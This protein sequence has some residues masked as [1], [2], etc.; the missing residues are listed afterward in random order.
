MPTNNDNISSN[1]YVQITSG[2][3]GAG[4]I[5]G[6]SLS[7]RVISTNELIP[8]GSIIEFSD[9]P[10]VAEYFGAQAAESARASYY[11]GY[12]SK[13]ISKPKKITFARW[14]ST[15]TSAQVFGSKSGTLADL[16]A[17]TTDNIKIT[18]DGIEGVITPDLSTI[19]SY[20]DAATIL[21][22]DIQALA[23]TFATATVA[24]DATKTSFNL[25]T[26]GVADGDI[27]ISASNQALLDALGWSNAINSAGVSAQSITEQLQAM[28]NISN[29]FGSFVYTDTLTLAQVSEAAIYTNEQNVVFMYHVPITIADAQTYYDELKGYGGVG[30]TINETAGEFA[31]ML[32]CAQLASQEFLR[33][34]ASANYMFIQDDRLTPSV[35]SDSVYKDLNALKINFMGRT[36]EAGTQISFYQAGVL[37]GPDTSPLQMGVFANEQWFKS[38]VKVE[39]LN[40]LTGL[41]IWPNDDTGIATGDTVLQS[42][43]NQALESNIIVLNKVFSNVEK[44]FINTISG[45]TTAISAMESR[46]YWYTGEIIEQVDAGVTKN[47]YSYIIIYATSEGVSKVVGR[48]NLV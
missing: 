46:G 34:G 28:V 39:F 10:S 3:G 13:Q 44:N 42:A 16:Q 35:T 24:F 12:L 17:F 43:I 2:V 45:D 47:V 25:D 14:A 37:L 21:E 23:G 9:S 11:F 31:E 33:P 32:P 26:N 7:C 30:L 15:D 40:T 5:A 29:D 6:R 19:A 41:N 22:T 38:Y 48:H 20:A 4:G 8:T 18:L 27:S 1:E 36:Q